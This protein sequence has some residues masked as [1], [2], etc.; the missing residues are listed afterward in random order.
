MASSTRPTFA[1]QR[2][3]LGR[4]GRPAKRKTHGMNCIA[5][6][7]LKEFVPAMN[8][9]PNQISSSAYIGSAW[10]QLSEKHDHRNRSSHTI[11]NKIH[12]EDPPLN[13]PLL[14]NHDRTPPLLLG[15]LNQIHGN[16]RRRNTDAYA[17]DKAT[18][19]QHA[20]TVT[21]RLDGGAQQPPQAGK[22][23]SFTATDAVGYRACHYS[24][25]D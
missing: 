25:N 23:D 1:S 22:G 8:E 15:D 16:L 9:Q 13:S 6:A 7:V 3:D 5:Q 2:G 10:P 20:H 17:I 12:N 14:N 24:T 11:S 19:H 4:K 21:T 18:N